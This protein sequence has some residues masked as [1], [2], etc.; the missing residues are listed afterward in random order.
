[1]FGGRSWAISVLLSLG[2]AILMCGCSD[3]APVKVGF[4]ASTSGQI[5]QLGQ[6]ARDGTLLAIEVV[7]AR[8]GVKG[9]PVVLENFDAAFA[10]AKAKEGVRFLKGKGVAA[11]I[12]PVA[13]Q[14]AVDIVPVANALKVPVISPTVTTP[15][16]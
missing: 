1:M 10:S 12:G 15:A 9:R 11:I 2:L 13:S 8:G 5:S 14:I 3:P 16:L 6:S 4:L 7:N